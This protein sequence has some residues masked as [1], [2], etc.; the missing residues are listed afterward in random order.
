VQDA[1]LRWQRADTVDRPEA[2]LT[3]VVTNLSLDRLTSARVQR[4]RYV[5][6]WLPEPVMTGGDTLGP[7]ETVEQRE[8]LS[9]GMLVLLERLTP[10]ERAAFVLR[11]AFGYSHREIAELLDV[12]EPHARQLYRRAQHHVAAE[13]KRFTATPD[14]RRELLQRFL[15]ATVAGDVP[16]LERMLAEDVVAWS[17]GG[18]KA[19][20]ARRPLVGRER[21]VRSLLSIAE[22]G[23]RIQISTTEVNGEPGL[24]LRLDGQVVGIAVPEFD[25]DRVAAIRAVANPDKL[26][27]FTGQIV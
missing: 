4:E 5:G 18:G 17:D 19:P 16:A 24:L 2:W 7:L 22:Y 25:G 13:R 26:A 1:Y 23:E 6:P 20:A 14:Q 11:E 3:K 8:S 21:V 15:A 10:P 27:Y 12:N 9:L